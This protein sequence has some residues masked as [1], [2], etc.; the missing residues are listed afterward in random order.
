VLVSSRADL[1]HPGSKALAQFPLS[2]TYAVA[3]VPI[4]IS[5]QTFCRHLS[6]PPSVPPSMPCSDGRQPA[7]R[8]WRRLPRRQHQIQ[9]LRLLFYKPWLNV[10]RLALLRYQHL[11]PVQA[12]PLLPPSP[13]PYTSPPIRRHSVRSYARTAL[14]SPSSHPRHVLRAA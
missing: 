10:P 1:S 5:P 12:H 8:P 13:P 11:D 3:D 4:Q 2:S 14:S 6:G 9:T 7:L